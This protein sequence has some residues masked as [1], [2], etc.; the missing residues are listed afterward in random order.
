MR[1]KGIVVAL[2]GLVVMHAS[3]ATAEPQQ[4]DARQAQAALQRADEAVR[5]AWSERALWTTA[6]E[7]LEQ[8]RTAMARGDHRGAMAAAGVAVEQAELGIAQSKYPGFQD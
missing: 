7:A 8:A 4:L 3:A 5:R 1:S 2:L 6:Q